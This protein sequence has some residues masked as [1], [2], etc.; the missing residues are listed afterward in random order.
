MASRWKVQFELHSQDGVVTVPDI[1]K[2]DQE[3]R[4][5]VMDNINWLDSTNRANPVTIKKVSKVT[6]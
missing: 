1:I 4:D 3:A 2:S 5:W 6:F